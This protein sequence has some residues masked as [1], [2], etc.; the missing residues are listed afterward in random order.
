VRTA[1]ALLGSLAAVPAYPATFAN[2]NGVPVEFPAG[3]ISFA[4]KVVEFTPGLNL[5]AGTGQIEPLPAYRR[6]ANVLGPP[7]MDITRSVSCFSS[8]N[9]QACGFVSLGVGGVLTV[10]FTDNLLSGSGTSAPDLWLFDMG[11]PDA[12][13]I[14]ISTDGNIWLNV[15]TVTTVPGV[16]IDAFG[17]G[18]GDTFAWV[19]LRDAPGGQ[20]NG[21]TVG[22][23]IDAIGAI[24]TTVVPLPA[25]GLLLATALAGLA[26]RRHFSPGDEARVPAGAR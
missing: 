21:P 9:D 6:A 1:I 17:H 26:V 7:D 5:N 3:A 16:D 11:T 15:G 24:S 12:F 23:D 8:P 2:I 18:V 4:D 22:A 10:K 25:P 14:D 13:F 20:P 19:R